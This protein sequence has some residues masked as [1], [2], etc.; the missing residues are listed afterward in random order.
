MICRYTARIWEE[1][2][3]PESAQL[4]NS[5]IKDADGVLIVTPEYNRNDARRIKERA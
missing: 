2:H 5:K 3:F 4:L 1:S